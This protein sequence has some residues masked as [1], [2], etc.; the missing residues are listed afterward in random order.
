MKL[1]PA[2]KIAEKFISKDRKSRNKQKQEEKK[3]IK[4]KKSLKKQVCT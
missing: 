4:T 3:K 1:L 2:K